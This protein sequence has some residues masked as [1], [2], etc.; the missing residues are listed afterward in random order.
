[1]MEMFEPELNLTTESDGSR[2]LTSITMTPNSCYDAGSIQVGYPDGYVGVPEQIAIT[3]ELAYNNS[4]GFCLMFV[5][6]ITH[7]LNNLPIID[8]HNELVVFTTL[9]LTNQSKYVILYLWN[10]ELFIK[11]VGALLKKIKQALFILVRRLIV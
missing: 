9:D 11:F 8:G 5:K 1:M 4:S 7:T 10:E 6:P 3:A 2:T